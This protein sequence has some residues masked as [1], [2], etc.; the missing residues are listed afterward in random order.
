MEYLEK[1]TK[2]GMTCVVSTM[3]NRPA[4]ITPHPSAGPCIS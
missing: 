3:V 2:L 1:I 4:A